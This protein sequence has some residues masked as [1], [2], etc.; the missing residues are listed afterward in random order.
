MITLHYYPSNA[1]MAPHMLLETLEIPYALQLVD[2]AH[3]AHKGPEYL[4]LNPNGLIP[5]LVDGDLVLYETA[6]ICLHLVDTHAHAGL[7]PPLGTPARAL[8]YQWLVWLT[9]TLQPT[10]IVYFYPERW[11]DT[12]EATA[13]VK[14]HAESKVG[15]LLDQLDAQLARHGKRWL[16]GET[17]SAVDPYALMLCRWTRGFARPARDLPQLGPYLQRLLALPAVQRVFE[18]EALPMPWV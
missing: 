7:A 4:K 17:F 15:G 8:F 12:P 9:N 5:V 1:S 6:A 11:A 18:R 2:R 13:Q 3:N 16:L 14:A 10:L